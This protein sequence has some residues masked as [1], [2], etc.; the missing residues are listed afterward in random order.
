[1][2]TEK[3]RLIHDLLDD[4]SRRDGIL[5]AGGK[6]LRRRRRWRMARQGLALVMVAALAAMWMGH[7]HP[8]TSPAQASAPTPK[9]L[10]PVRPKPLTDDELL[11]MFPDT[12]VALATL[13][14]GRKQLIFPRPADQKRFLTRL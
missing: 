8:R 12:P 6:I 9:A 11:A 3:Q 7:R 13:A 5:L 4:E 14:N 10:E 1:M 2:K